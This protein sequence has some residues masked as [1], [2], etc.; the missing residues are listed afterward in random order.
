MSTRHSRD[1]EQYMGVI[2]TARA[3]LRTVL[4]VD[5]DTAQLG[6]TV[7]LYERV[8]TFIPEI[9]PLGITG[10]QWDVACEALFEERGL[11]APEPISSVTDAAGRRAQFIAA[12]EDLRDPQTLA[13]MRT[14]ALQQLAAS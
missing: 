7:A 14:L 13:Q 12:M 9:R 5:P 11:L 4:D 3:L 1:D 2:K 6:T 8:R 10:L